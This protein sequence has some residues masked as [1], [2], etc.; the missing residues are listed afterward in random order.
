MHLLACEALARALSKA[1]MNIPNLLTIFR[2]LLAPAIVGCLV[3]YDAHRDWM[4]LLALGLFCLGMLTDALDGF[5]ARTQNQRTE[6]GTL[7]D[8][9]ADKLLILATLISCSVIRGLPDFMRLPAWFNLVVIS[10]DS[11]LIAGAIMFFFVKAKWSVTPSWIGKCT[12]AAQ[13]AVV[14]T[15]LLGL[16]VKQPVI[17]VATVFTVVSGIDYIRSGIRQLG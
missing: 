13:M 9:I 7:L 10:R 3:Y 15:L 17:L 14:P 6:L 11:L 16:P 8:P 5:I 2:I 12:T 1:D 4:R